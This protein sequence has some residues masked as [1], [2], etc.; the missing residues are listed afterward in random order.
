MDMVIIMNIWIDGTYGS[1][2]SLLAKELSMKIDNSI[3]YKYDDYIDEWK[4]TNSNDVVL[5]TLL[6]YGSNHSNIYNL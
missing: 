3:L 5:S 2:K 1:G 4:K 6:F